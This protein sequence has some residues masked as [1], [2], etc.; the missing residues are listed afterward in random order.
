MAA[1]RELL[2]EAN[3]TANKIRLFFVSEPN[4][5]IKG[6]R[7]V[8]IVEDSTESNINV[9]KDYDEQIEVHYFPFD[10]SDPF[11]PFDVSVHFLEPYQAVDVLCRKIPRE[12]R[13]QVPL[14]CLPLFRTV[15]ASPYL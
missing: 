4:S 8:Y 10:V 15:V 11:N 1:R 3:L 7:Y 6:K 14:I 9:K 13:G 12:E 5:S 2:E